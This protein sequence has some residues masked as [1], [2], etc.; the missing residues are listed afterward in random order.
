M[1]ACLTLKARLVL[2]FRNGP[3]PRNYLSRREQ[4]RLFVLVMFLLGVVWIAFEARNPEHYSWIWR[5]GGGNETADERVDTRLAPVASAADDTFIFPRPG[6]PDDENGPGTSGPLTEAGLA[7]IRDGE[8]F[9]ASENGAWFKLFDRLQKTDSA[10]LRE[11]ST[12]PVTFIQLYRQP[13][14]YRAELVTLAGTLRRSE[15]VTAPRND[16]GIESYYMTWLSPRDHPSDPIVVYTLTVPDD[17]PQGM[18]IEEQVELEGFFFK[19][20]PYEAQDGGRSAPVVLAKSLRWIATEPAEPAPP[21]SPAGVVGLAALLAGLLVAVVW[22][23][24]RHKRRDEPTQELFQAPPPDDSS[25]AT[26][27]L[28]LMSDPDAEGTPE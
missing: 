8:P 17:F 1:S 20:W 12:G 11:Q 3:R 27:H 22:W 21:I 14:E 15:P 6:D 10:T 2:Q 18:A 28:R 16:M 26:S 24:T 5:L 7:S 23:Q 4:K 13:K 9:R 25:P 19:R